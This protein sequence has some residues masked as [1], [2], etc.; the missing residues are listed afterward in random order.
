MLLPL[1]VAL[2][3]KD[4]FF[5]RNLLAAWTPLALVA[6][7]GLAA[8]RAGIAVAAAICALGVACTVLFATDPSL[9]RQ[10]WRGVARALGPP[11]PRAVVIGPGYD[12]TLELYATRLRPFPESAALRE[13]DAVVVGGERSPRAPAG[14]HPAGSRDF[15][16]LRLLRFRAARAVVV[17]R[18]ALG[19]RLDPAWAPILLLDG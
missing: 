13:V 1:L 6:A 9:Q 2:A 8:R 3:G 14:F 5:H 19:R 16:G 7:S 4:Y 12:F 10:N 15:E 18:A 11:A 17:P